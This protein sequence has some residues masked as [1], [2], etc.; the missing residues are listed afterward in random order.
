MKKAC[1]K[2]GLPPGL[3][4]LLEEMTDV[5][6]AKRPSIQ[7]VV[8]KSTNLHVSDPRWGKC[9]LL[10]LLKTHAGN[11]AD[12]EIAPGSLVKSLTPWRKEAKESQQIQSLSQEAVADPGRLEELRARY[13]PTALL[14][15]KVRRG[16]T[17][18]L[19][20]TVLTPGQLCSLL[21]PFRA[22]LPPTTA[23]YLLL[24]L[25]IVDLQAGDVLVSWMANA[26]HVAGL[27][28]LARG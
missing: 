20:A 18:T 11:G 25:A 5:V 12:E 17:K 15:L 28:W 4:T 9:C 2:R 10:M 13:L 24:V 22:T 6:P 21:P 14:L 1:A 23:L 16:E 27:W 19:S 8:Q 3:L 26:C 7:K